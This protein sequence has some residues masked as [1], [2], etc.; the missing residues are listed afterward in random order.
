MNINVNYSIYNRTVTANI[1]QKE[2]DLSSMIPDEVWGEKMEFPLHPIE[3]HKIRARLESFVSIWFET[4]VNKIVGWGASEF[5]DINAKDMFN[6]A[7][8]KT[9]NG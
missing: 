8:E 3:E 2:Y 7:E 5:F 9:Q 1:D 4:N 6:K